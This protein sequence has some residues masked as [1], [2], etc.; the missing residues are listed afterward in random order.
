M[1]SK[2]RITFIRLRP[3]RAS[4]LAFRRPSG[5]LRSNG[6]SY[7]ELYQWEDGICD[8]CPVSG[9]A[10]FGRAQG[11]E[12]AVEVFIDFP[13]FLQDN[14]L[15][16]SDLISCVFSLDLYSGTVVPFEAYSYDDTFLGDESGLVGDGELLI[17]ALSLYQSE[18]VVDV[19]IVPS[20]SM[21]AVTELDA[22]HSSH[23]MALVP[24]YPLEISVQTPPARTAYM[25]GDLFSPAGMVVR[26]RYRWAGW[27]PV[28]GYE[29]QRTPLAASQGSVQ[30]SYSGFSASVSI[31]VYPPS[32]LGFRDSPELNVGE[33]PSFE[34]AIGEIRFAV[35]DVSCGGGSYEISASHVYRSGAS[36]AFCALF[37]GY[38]EGFMLSLDQRVFPLGGPIVRWVD[39]S[40]SNHSFRLFDEAGGRYYD[41]ADPSIVLKDGLSGW[42]IEF[43]DGACLGF[44]SAGRL[45][46]VS[47]PG[48]GNEKVIARHSDGR[49]WRVYDLRKTEGGAVLESLDFSYDSALRLASIERK[50]GGAVPERTLFS[51]SGPRLTSVRRER[52][53]GGSWLTAELTRFEYDGSGRMATAAEASSWAAFRTF[54]SGGAVSKVSKG[55]LTEP[56]AS[57]AEGQIADKYAEEDYT[58]FGNAA[59]RRRA[60]SPKDG[61]SLSYQWDS[62]GRL[63]SVLEASMGGLRTLE[64]P[65]GFART[66]LKRENDVI[67]ELPRQQGAEGLNGESYSAPSGQFSLRL[68]PDQ[69]DLGHSL[70]F[71]LEFYAMLPAESSVPLF[72]E[73][74]W[75]STANQNNVE[76]H[77]TRAEANRY[78]ASVWQRIQI[79]IRF[80]S[81]AQRAQDLLVS[82]G[83]FSPGNAPYSS[84]DPVIVTKPRIV[85]GDLPDISLVFN[86]FYS[87]FD[88][89]SLIGRETEFLLRAPD[90]PGGEP[91]EEPPEPCPDMAESDVFRAI[92][93]P[94]ANGDGTFDLIVEGGRR[95]IAGIGE[96]FAQIGNVPSMN[97]L[98]LSTWSAYS[99]RSA[100]YSPAQINGWRQTQAYEPLSGGGLHVRRATEWFDSAGSLISA[101]PSEGWV[102]YDP[103]GNVASESRGEGGASLNY[104]RAPTGELTRAYLMDS[105]ENEA[106][107]Y[108]ATYDPSGEFLSSEASF[109]IV[110]AY[111]YEDGLASSV[112]E[113]P[114]TKVFSYDLPRKRLTGVSFSAGSLVVPSHAVGYSAGL[115]SSMSGGPFAH[116]FA[117]TFS[118]YRRRVEYERNGA[119]AEATEED[120]Q[121]RESS[122]FRSASSTDIVTTSFS[123]PYRRPASQSLNGVAKVTFQYRSDSAYLYD[124][125][126]TQ[127]SDSYCGRATQMTYGPG[128]EA[129]KVR[130][131]PSASQNWSSFSAQHNLSGGAA[132]YATGA[133]DNQVLMAL[134]PERVAGFA[135]ASR[136]S[137]PSGDYL[138]KRSDDGFGR[139]S[140]TFFG[141]YHKESFTYDG[142]SRLQALAYEFSN[143]AVFSESLQYSNGLVTQDTRNSQAV[144]YSRDDA[145]RL[146]SETRGAV[147]KTFEYDGQGRL[148]K[149]KVGGAVAVTFEYDAKSRLSKT[150]PAGQA[151]TVYGYDD[152]G[153]LTSKTRGNATTVFTYER[154]RLLS[155]AGPVAFQYDCAERRTRKANVEYFY[156]GD[157][158][159]AEYI[160]PT[161]TQS[162]GWRTYFYDDRGVRGYAQGQSLFLYV[163][164]AFGSIVG[165]ATEWGGLIGTYTYDTFGVPTISAADQAAEAIL[166]ENPFRWKGYYYDSET[167]LYWVGSRYYDPEVGRFITPDDPGY[168]DP[169][170]VAGLDPYVYC[171]YDPVNYSDPTGH[172]AIW[173][174]VLIGAA[175][176][177]AVTFVKDWVDDGR[178]FNGSVSW[179][180]YVGA[181]VGG[182]ISGLGTGF[183]STVLFSGLGSVA[184]SA[185]MGNIGS[186]SDFAITFGIGA[187]VGAIGYVVTAGIR[188]IGNKKVMGVIGES[189][190]NIRINKRLAEAGFKNLKVGKLGYQGVYDALYKHFGF[191]IVENVW[192]VAYGVG[193]GF[194]PW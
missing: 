179:Q 81:E 137:T 56:L 126:P 47:G 80:A 59:G 12:L 158:L 102:T 99:L 65:R 94:L 100:V 72:F 5:G 147:A 55:R 157:R 117:T 1:E 173:A 14:G 8:G 109:G 23:E 49:I 113:G 35:P 106:D 136:L 46:S 86:A 172:F 165:I 39:G 34:L 193:T 36:A 168:L 75:S 44:D 112:T 26:A 133:G 129:S 2:A 156:D 11:A 105:E 85:E 27:Q 90:G 10:A 73:A 82:V 163:R 176:G 187:A 67:S 88:S 50:E 53:S 54:Y 175:I 31:E 115:L 40:G 154:G 162:G 174:S 79:P 3:E 37:W 132:V 186:F 169:E 63:A 7:V 130:Q 123:G 144:V 87:F 52:L 101:P 143:S 108:S 161:L 6:D 97:L 148:W 118:A 138:M 184:Q 166:G 76:Y 89:F 68:N 164:D 9:P 43:P 111:G 194:L 159:V 25:E 192:Q 41:E 29:Y 151:Q 98:K 69:D 121:E 142:S 141:D 171:H 28:S 32:A 155:S 92:C 104:E 13:A 183:V 51:Y 71:R 45:C 74:V 42:R 30:I 38:G 93:R 20:S 16:A 178:P 119:L 58:E 167:G 83:L 181:G 114:L 177:L 139:P 153:N 170:S 95:R 22:D 64:R 124:D 127:I 135:S 152:R 107:I 110:K 33:S 191:E 134:S 146:L 189:T 84:S 185:I 122:F 160:E 62:K 66:P 18:G 17:N 180:E 4:S 145:G 116:S 140:A 128:G 190:R 91:P 150:I 21:S 131:T 48:S 57:I 182:A 61:P 77:R 78:A 60:V 15:S 188:V 103:R 24:D 125:G 120:A 96:F 149:I 70:R 19:L